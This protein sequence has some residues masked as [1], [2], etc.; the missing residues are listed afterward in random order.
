MAEKKTLQKRKTE[1]VEKVERTHDRNVFIPVVD[2][3]ETNDEII[4]M[5]EMPGVDEKSIDVTLDND[6]LTIRGRAADESPE[7]YELVYS[8][9]EVG[10][11]ERS[12]SINESIDADKIEAQYTNGV[13]TVKLPKAEPAKAKKIE[14]KIK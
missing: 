14:V 7:G 12:F 9:Y 1:Q 11:F 5:A 3:Y 4:L 6:I 10:D 8:E 2:I 13:L